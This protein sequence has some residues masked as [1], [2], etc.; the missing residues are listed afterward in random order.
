VDISVVDAYS[1]MELCKQKM[2]DGESFS[3]N[4]KTH[5]GHIS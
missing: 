3:K 5:K 1:G 2:L 4:F